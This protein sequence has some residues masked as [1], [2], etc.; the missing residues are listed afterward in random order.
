MRPASATVEYEPGP[1]PFV[2][3]I[4]AL[5]SGVMIVF[6][7]HLALLAWSTHETRQVLNSQGRHA[8]ATVVSN[9]DPRPAVTQDNTPWTLVVSY[10][11]AGHTYV[12]SVL[13]YPSQLNPARGAAIDIVYDP[14]HPSNA[15][16]VGDT[17]VGV[18]RACAWWWFATAGI[19]A[20]AGCIG[21]LGAVDDRRRWT[22]VWLVGLVCA[23]SLMAFSAE[24]WF[25][26]SGLRYP[27]HSTG[28]GGG[29][30]RVLS[31]SPVDAGRSK[32]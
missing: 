18:S 27:T 11:V 30:A 32:A 17:G 16:I 22:S 1:R 7:V 19:A 15:A 29:A 24:I 13:N 4:V 14:A 12:R 20:I 23:V 21:V 26:D 31:P 6:A 5:L 10:T 28:G 3:S 8:R 25:R 2:H 9:G